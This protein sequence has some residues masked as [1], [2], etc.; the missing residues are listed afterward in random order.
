L[1]LE[2]DDDGQ[3]IVETLEMKSSR[4]GKTALHFA[5]STGQRCQL[6]AL[7]INASM[8][9]K[10]IPFLCFLSS[11]SDVNPNILDRSGR[12]PIHYAIERNDLR[13]VTENSKKMFNLQRF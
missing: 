8:I 2:C 5:A 6:L 13:M 7:L 11:N 3:Y 10:I 12:A 4:C 9:K 1:R